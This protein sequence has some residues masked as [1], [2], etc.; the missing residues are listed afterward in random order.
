[1]VRIKNYWQKWTIIPMEKG[2]IKLVLE[3]FVDP[4]GTVP[5]WLYNMVITDTPLKVM[6]EVQKRV[7]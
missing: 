3:G 7:E 6:R 4:G 5:A 1:M 2:V